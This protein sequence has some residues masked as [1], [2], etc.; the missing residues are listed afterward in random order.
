M[1]LTTEQA[2]AKFGLILPC[3]INNVEEVLA[4]GFAPWVKIQG[5]EFLEVDGLQAEATDISNR[6][7]PLTILPGQERLR[8][9]FDHRD[10]S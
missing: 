9:V 10:I 7:D 4:V 5:L 8:T 1:K 6:T 3:T 2:I